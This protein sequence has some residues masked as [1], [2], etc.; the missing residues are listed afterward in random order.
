MIPQPQTPSPPRLPVP[1]P[2]TQKFNLRSIRTK[3]LGQRIPNRGSPPSAPTTPSARWP[4][5]HGH[6]DSPTVQHDNSLIRSDPIPIPIPMVRVS[7]SKPAS[8]SSLRCRRR[9]RPSSTRLDSIRLDSSVRCRSDRRAAILLRACPACP[10]AFLLTS[11]LVCVV[12]LPACGSG[13]IYRKF[14]RR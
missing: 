1:D 12:C 14:G 11:A 4:G 10:P 5:S 6:P 8:V 7:V 3:H 13:S 9:F 2:N